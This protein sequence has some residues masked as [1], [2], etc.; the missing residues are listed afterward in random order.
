MN[1]PAILDFGKIIEIF[2]NIAQPLLDW[3]ELSELDGQKL[4]ERE[5][6]IRK[7]TLELAG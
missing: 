4:M 5:Q 3:N 6:E 2:I 7:A 1:I